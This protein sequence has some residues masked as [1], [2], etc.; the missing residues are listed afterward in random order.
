MF[1][2]FNRING[3][4]KSME[5]PVVPIRLEIR[6]PITNKV[7]F[8]NG[9]AFLSISISIPPEAIYKEVL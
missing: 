5:A 8:A 3:R 9:V 4:I 1:P 6:A 7:T 2:L